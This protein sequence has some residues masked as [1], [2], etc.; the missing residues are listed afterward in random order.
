MI[1]HLNLDTLVSAGCE[2]ITFKPLAKE[3]VRSQHQGR[4][5]RRTDQNNAEHV[6]NANDQPS[7]D[8]PTQRSGVSNRRITGATKVEE[9]SNHQRHDQ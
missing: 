4:K 1:G 8:P 5:H 2:S 6:A 9:N 3:P 7:G